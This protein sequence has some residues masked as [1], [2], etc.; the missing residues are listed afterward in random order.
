MLRSIG[1]DFS[2][3]THLQFRDGILLGQIVLA[4]AISCSRCWLLCHYLWPDV[5]ITII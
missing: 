2:G 4:P 3:Q 5:W 1:E